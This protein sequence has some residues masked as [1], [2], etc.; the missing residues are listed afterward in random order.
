MLAQAH[1]IDHT[2]VMDK[3]LLAGG[4]GRDAAIA[5]RLAE[6]QESE[7]HLVAEYENPTLARTAK[8][9]GGRLYVVESVCDGPVLA[10]IAQV[11]GADLVW[12]NQD[13]ALANGVIDHIKRRVPQILSA[14]PQREG[15][16][17]EFD[18][19]D[20][21]ELVAEI[22][23]QYGTNFNPEYYL[24]STFDE[25]M[26]WTDVFRSKGKNAVVKPRGLTG[27]KGVKV[28]GKHFDTYDQVVQYAWEVVQNPGQGGVV[29]EEEMQGFE[30]TVQA[31][32]DGRTLIVPP[33]T[34][35][36]PYREDGDV[37]PGTGGM[38][39]FT[40]APGD[41]PLPFLSS[42][43][44]QQATWPMERVLEKLND[45]N[46]DFKGILYGSFFKTPEG[47]KVVEFN[48]RL[49]CPEGMNIMELQ[50]DNVSLLGLLKRIATGELRHKDM[51]FKNLASAVLYLV[52][53]GYAYPS[54]SGVYD[55]GLNEKII[56]E[57]DCRTYFAAAESIKGIRGKYQ[58]VGSSRTVALATTA[59]TP[60]DARKKIDNA[61]AAAVTG[62]LQYRND[63]A[64]KD[65]IDQMT[66]SG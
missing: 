27:G 53:P 65:Y 5:T 17:V 31:P 15:A 18:K 35:D 23:K 28:M 57:M 64:S 20:S 4:Y 39:C 8:Q 60:W 34:Y 46:R 42:E 52:S 29:L 37:G 63:V 56:T 30:F 32:T 10:D 62:P 45:R 19:F 61:I 44:Y 59:D 16:R 49:G 43:E 40:I 55:F 66:V 54:N 36:Y 38:G 22:D 48:A 24:A 9:T 33:P 25:I 58:T 47:I 7:L 1:K 14:S 41:K 3:V 12:I 11:A 26:L 50:E 51:R 13:N 6:Q 2:I 21:R